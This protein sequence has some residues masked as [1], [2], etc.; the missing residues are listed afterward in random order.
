MTITGEHLTPL[1][2]IAFAPSDGSDAFYSSL[3]SLKSLLQPKTPL[4]LLL[5]RSTDPKDGLTF[6][7]YIPYNSPVRSKTLFASTRTTL[8]EIGGGKLSSQHLAA[9]EAEVY[10]ED[11]WHERF[12]E[13]GLDHDQESTTEERDLDTFKHAEEAKALSMDKRDIGIGG[14][15]GQ[16]ASGER[17]PL[18]SIGEGVED[19]MKTLNEE[20][21]LVK[22]VSCIPNYHYCPHRFAYLIYDLRCRPWTFRRNHWP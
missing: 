8:R 22:L 6:L 19:A 13:K 20:G 15:I 17:K 4:Y 11:I 16:D 12:H 5:R 2:A 14:S 7:T 3:P 21:S 9:E 10:S 1:D 18:F